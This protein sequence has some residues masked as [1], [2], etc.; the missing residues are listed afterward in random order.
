MHEILISWRNLLLI[1]DTRIKCK[2]FYCLYVR[3][4][5]IIDSAYIQMMWKYMIIKHIYKKIDS[6]NKYDFFS[7]NFV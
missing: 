3:D 1:I 5:N 7:W 6:T 4:I 2:S